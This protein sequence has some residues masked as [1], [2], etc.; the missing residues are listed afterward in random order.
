MRSSSLLTIHFLD[1]NSATLVSDG[2]SNHDPDEPKLV[3]TPAIAIVDDVESLT[4]QDR[5][6]VVDIQLSPAHA[7]VKLP[8]SKENPPPSL[9]SSRQP[10]NTSWISRQSPWSTPPPKSPRIPQSYTKPISTKTTHDRPRPNRLGAPEPRIHASRP[11]ISVAG[12]SRI[13]KQLNSTPGRREVTT[14]DQ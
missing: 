3:D 9:P 6:Q 4:L 13:S 8:T 2:S 7:T 5:T 12:L 10:K 14:G 11:I 1:T